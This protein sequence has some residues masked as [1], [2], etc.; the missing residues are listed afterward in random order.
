MQTSRRAW[1]KAATGAA[2]AVPLVFVAK[3]SLAAKNDALRNSLKYQ[4]TPSGSKRCDN[5]LQWVPGKTPKDRGGCK[6]LPGDTEIS[7]SGYCVAWV[8]MKK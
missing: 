5:C 1:L 8:E 7:P 3:Q 6:I 4:D 2:V